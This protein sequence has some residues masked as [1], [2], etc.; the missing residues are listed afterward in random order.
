[1]STITTKIM[2]YKI[3]CL[4]LAFGLLASLGWA[5][6]TAQYT[7]YMY[8]TGLI[9]PGYSGSRGT[10]TITGLHRS[11]WMGIDGAPSTQSFNFDTNFLNRNT[12]LGLAV[13]NDV[14]G[15]AKQTGLTVNY[16]YRLNFSDNYTLSLGISGS[17]DFL[18]VD[19]S[20]L[21]TEQPETIEANNGMTP[22]VGVGAFF[23]SNRAYLGFSVPRLLKSSYFDSVNT[24]TSLDVLTHFYLIGGVVLDLDSNIKFKPAFLAKAVSGAPLAADLSANFLFNDKFT[25]GAAYR[26]DAAVSLLAAFQITDK[27]LIGS[28]YDKDINGFGA[29]NNGSFEVF[30]K[31]NFKRERQRFI[32]NPRFF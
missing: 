6:Q 32:R 25:L 3:R 19:V 20:Q 11:Q 30:L 2:T 28:A 10:A 21:T 8:N 27:L 18:D 31:F 5:Q 17:L 16:A 29:L 9:N 14:A 24:F 12:G 13:D 22:N 26:W 1:M 23:Y 7:D 4:M 15:P